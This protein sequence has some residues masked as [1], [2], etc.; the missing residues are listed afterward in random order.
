M[1]RVKID[2]AV[3]LQEFKSANTA[4]LKGEYSKFLITQYGAD[5]TP[6]LK[7]YKYPPRPH[8]MWLHVQ[9]IIELFS[10]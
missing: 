7:R 3:D 5:S 4:G 6:P 2:S 9:Q 1:E 10:K 8:Q